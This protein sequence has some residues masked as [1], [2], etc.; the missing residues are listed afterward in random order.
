M[1]EIVKDSITIT[2][3]GKPF[4]VGKHTLRYTVDY[5]A[6]PYGKKSPMRLHSHE[7]ATNM[8]DAILWKKTLIK[9]VI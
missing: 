5:I 4:K 2:K 7:F 8:K 9:E 1:T 6:Y 3:L